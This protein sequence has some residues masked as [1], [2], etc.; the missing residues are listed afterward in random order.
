MNYRVEEKKP[1]RM[2]GVEKTFSVIN[3]QCYKDIPE[4]WLDAM[5]DKTLERILNLAS[6]KPSTITGD[7][8]GN[9]D[10]MIN[11]AMYGHKSDGT[12]KYMLCAYTPDQ[13]IPKEYVQL[14]VPALTWAIFPTEKHQMHQTTELTQ[15]IWKRIYAEWFPSSGYEH[16]DAPEFEMYYN[17]GNDQYIVEVWIPVINN[18]N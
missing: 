13:E 15:D 2:F 18:K 10:K 16:A 9:E 17:V 4:F 6:N 8:Y 12:L 14:E 3:G 7:I 11:A 1:F 5:K